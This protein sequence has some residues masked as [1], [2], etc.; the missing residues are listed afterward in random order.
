MMQFDG[1]PLILGQLRQGG[2]QC[3]QLL[4]ALG[5]FARR[6]LFRR[7]PGLDARRRLVES[8]LQRTLAAD[9]AGRR[10]ELADLVAQVIGQGVPQPGRRQHPHLARA[11]CLVGLEKR[12]LHHAGQVHLALQASVEL[13]P[14]QQAQVVAEAFRVGR[15]TSHARSLVEEAWTEEKV[16]ART[17]FFYTTAPRPQGLCSPTAGGVSFCGSCRGNERPGCRQGKRLSCDDGRRRVR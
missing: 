10:G 8:G 15:L 13:Q 14:G 1:S 16:Y 6:R 4:I 5:L 17:P 3:Q 7:Q 12:L 2:G 9:V 11:Q